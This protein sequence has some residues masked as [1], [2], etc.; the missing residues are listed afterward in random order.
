[1]TSASVHYP[2]AVRD[3]CW[4]PQIIGSSRLVDVAYRSQDRS[5]AQKIHVIHACDD[6]SGPW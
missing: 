5:V 1:V 2:H 6:N 3:E 4:W